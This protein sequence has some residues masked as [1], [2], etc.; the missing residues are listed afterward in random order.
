MIGYC[1]ERIRRRANFFEQVYIRV[2]ET[3][4]ICHTCF[5]NK[6]DFSYV[7]SLILWSLHSF[8]TNSTDFLI[9][10]PKYN[11]ILY[12]SEWWNSSVTIVTKLRTER[13]RIRDQITTRKKEILLFSKNLVQVPR[14]IKPP[15]QRAPLCRLLGLRV[16]IPTEAWICL[17]WMLWDVRHRSL[18]RPDNPSRGVLLSVVCLSDRGN[19]QRLLS[20]KKKSAEEWTWTLT[21]TST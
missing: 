13:Q 10:Y 6:F 12:T 4:G 11:L 14:P 8:I 7:I 21:L 2:H 18:R 15:I 19:S 9:M 17:F 20:H 3:S 5:V 1:K 16:R